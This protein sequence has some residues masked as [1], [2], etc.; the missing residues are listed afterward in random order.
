MM[1]GDE[2]MKLGTGGL[3]MGGKAR[4]SRRVMGG[5]VRLSGP[6]MG[7]IDEI[8]E[9]VETSDGGIGDRG[10]GETVETS[11]AWGDW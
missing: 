8:G 5:L 10:K 4:L 11:D 3:V 9:T 7:G 1:R 6:M 2:M